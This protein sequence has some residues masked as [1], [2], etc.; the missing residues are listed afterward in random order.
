MLHKFKVEAYKNGCEVLVE[1]SVTRVT[2]RRH[3]AGR[4]MPN[5]YP[6]DGIFQFAP[7]THYGF[8]FLHTLPT[9]IAFRLEYVL[10][11]FISFTL[12]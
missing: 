7:K 3:E 12:K 1:N 5:S 2:V 8:I 9:T 4:V 11:C 6:S 10:C